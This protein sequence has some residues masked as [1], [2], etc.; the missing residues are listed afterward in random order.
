MER[1]N[2]SNAYCYRVRGLYVP[3]ET[4]ANI[5]KD[6]DSYI[7]RIEQYTDRL[8]DTYNNK[9]KAG[10]INTL[11]T[12]QGMLQAVF[13]KQCLSYANALI[14][15]A[16]NRSLEYCER[17]LQQAIADFLLLSIEM[18]KAQKL[19]VNRPVKYRN[20]EKNED[21]SHG[22]ASISR[23][24]EVRDYT[25]A[26]S[27]ANDLK[28]LSDTFSKAGEMIKSRQY[29]RAKEMAEKVE[30]EHIKIIEQGGTGKSAKTIL[31]V[32][33]RPEILSSVN[34]A[35]R[36]HYKVLGAPS[37]KIALQIMAKQ[38]IDLFYLDIEMPEMDGFE[39]YRQIRMI[40]KYKD[41]PIIFLTSNASRE[42]I[43]RGINLGVSDYIVKPSNHV[44]LIVKARKY[45]DEA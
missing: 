39:L 3:Y 22:L 44:N 10:F 12:V 32:D 33:D 29:D 15:A 43:S 8:T 37:G 27:I 30:K 17:L 25:G 19:N 2:D 16:T 36:N 9:D 1:K 35:L 11:E 40:Q 41:T 23:S 20:I 24:I 38:H 34:A 31:A 42:Y 45:M 28:D 14:D 7:N 13:A 21:I 4:P 5:E 6:I 26:E 18:Q